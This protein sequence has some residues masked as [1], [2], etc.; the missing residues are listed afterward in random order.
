MKK[1]VNTKNREELII[2]TIKKI[3]NAK[4]I[5]AFLLGGIVAMAMA[6]GISTVGLIFLNL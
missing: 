6:L 2:Q 5:Q 3:A 4:R 1:A